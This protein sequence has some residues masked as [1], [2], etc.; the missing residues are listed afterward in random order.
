MSK[1]H[2]APRARLDRLWTVPLELP[3][4]RMSVPR[5]R[6]PAVVAASKFAARGGGTCR[7]AHTDRAELGGPKGAQRQPLRHLPHQGRRL[8]GRV[9]S[10]GSTNW[11][12][13]E[14]TFVLKGQPSGPGYKAQNNTLAVFTDPDAVSRFTAELIAEHM[15]ATSGAL[16]AVAPVPPPIAPSLIR[17]PQVD[18]RRP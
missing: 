13:S 10:E 17:R 5:T 7:T 15:A 4:A 11:S 3:G 16:A 9:G 12:T 6:A 14:G 8:D 18:H 1:T 2:R